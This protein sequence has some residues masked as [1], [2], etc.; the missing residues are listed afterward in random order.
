MTDQ[1]SSLDSTGASLRKLIE[2]HGH[3]FQYHCMRQGEQ[4]FAAKRS[5]WL[6]EVAEFPVEVRNAQ[7]R[8]DFI[9]SRR[10]RPWYLLAECKRA[11]PARSKWAFARAPYV[12]RNR[13][14][15]PYIAERVYNN[16]GVAG[17]DGVPVGHY[18]DKAY[19]VGLELKTGE[20]GDQSGAGRNAIEEAASQVSRALSGFVN[21]LGGNLHLL[22]GDQTVFVFPVIFTTAELWTTEADIGDV[23]PATGKLLSEV[24]AARADWVA[25]QYHLSPGVKHPLRPSTIGQSIGE[26]LDA[27]YLRTI[28]VVSATAIP[29]FLAW[30]SEL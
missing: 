24:E 18:F 25:F 22:R 27:E 13:I 29:K 20:K 26:I 21:F 23:V 15:E 8:I 12:R 3:A 9:L 19:H 7:T 16:Q 17:A 6:F 2:S 14:P 5:S 10:D 4:E 11:D 28:L 1:Q 30:M